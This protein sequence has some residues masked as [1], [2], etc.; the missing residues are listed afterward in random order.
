MSSLVFGIFPEARHGAD[1]GH[2]QKGEPGHFQPQLV[3]H[4]PERT[5]GGTH[6]TDH[7]G[8]GPG[9]AELLGGDLGDPA[10]LFRARESHY[11]SILAAPGRTICVC[12]VT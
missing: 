11:W 10:Q 12:G 5:Q 4:A 3:K 9:A 7:S 2:R 1:S 8:A 6:A